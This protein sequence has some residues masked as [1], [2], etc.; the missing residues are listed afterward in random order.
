MYERVWLRRSNKSAWIKRDLGFTNCRS[1]SFLEATPAPNER[2]ISI[3]VFS[4]ANNQI[5]EACTYE[6]V[7]WTAWRMAAAGSMGRPP[8]KYSKPRD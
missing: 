6:A 1:Y 2:Q 4:N 8:K 3:F 5:T 7:R